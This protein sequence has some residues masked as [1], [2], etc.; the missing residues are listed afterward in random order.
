MAAAVVLAAVSGVVGAALAQSGIVNAVR[1]EGNQRVEPETVRAYMA[2]GPGEAF[3]AQAIDRSLKALF[4]TEIFADVTIRR[5]GDDLVVRVVEN[6][7]INRL[8]FEGNKRIEDPELE[9]EV[10]LRPRVA[11]TRAKVQADVA[12]IL[13]IYRRS[14][15]FAATVEPKVIRQEQNRVDLIFEIDEGERTKVRR[16]SF[17]GN[18]AFSDSKL[19][20]VVSTK[21]SAWYRFLSDDDAYDPDR[22]TFDRELLRRYYMSEGYA[23]V[24]IV[25]AT[26]DLTQDRKDFFITFTLQEGERYDFGTVRVRSALPDLAS[27]NLHPYVTTF[28][29]DRYNADEVEATIQA[30]VDVVG[31]LGY[32]FVEITPVVNRDVEAHTIDVTYDI[33]QG[34]RVYVER[35]NIDG[36]VRTLDRVIRREFKLAEGDAFSTAKLRRFEQRIRNLDFFETVDITTEE[37]SAPDQAVI[38]VEVAEKSTGE[39]SFGFGFSTGDGLVGDIQLRERNLLGK[40]Q[41]LSIDTTLSGRRQQFDISF[42]EPAFLE[43]DDLS[44]GFD[45]FHKTTDLQA[46]SSHDQTDSGGGLRL[47]YPLTER[48]S[49]SVRYVARRVKISDVKSNASRFIRQQKGVA[50]TSLIGHDLIYDK[51]D[52]RINPTEGYL[53]RFSQDIAGI[54]GSVKFL[55]NQLSTSG[56]YEFD[57]DWVGSV[58]LRAGHITGLFGDDVRI[59]DRFFLGGTSLRGFK[60]SGVSP[61]DGQTSDA[62]GG[63]A[64]WTATAEL[65]YPLGLP[66]EIGLLGRV[67][68]DVGADWD[69]DDSGSNIQDSSAPRVVIGVGATYPSAMGPIKIDFSEAIV[70]EDFDETELFRFSF[71]TRF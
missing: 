62:L 3:D 46:E 11:Y 7:I 23:D 10:Q 22:L 4:A 33:T 29:G 25:S 5:E 30:L 34:P 60:T 66:D 61:R 36:N 13:E 45:L 67:F 39:L 21:E 28:T 8:A 63:K 69:S 51:V 64:M 12:R 35:I 17:V 58:Q 44:A 54:G 2:I 71:G 65:T 14:G 47:G 56:Y 50:V 68:T 40:G 18:E 9:A 32:A 57:D 27:T 48:L 49:H 19:R 59:N 38:N 16:I 42:T 53:V 31:G 37:G 26:A 70:K 20:G 24:A 43:R 1:V 15:R 52:S 6:P 41:D 55:R